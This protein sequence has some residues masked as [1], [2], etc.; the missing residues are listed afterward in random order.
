MH[1]SDLNNACS[2][3]GLTSLVLGEEILVLEGLSL[4]T[5]VTLVLGPISETRLDLSMR[6]SVKKAV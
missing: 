5:P 1:Y 4:I 3:L 6:H 2:V